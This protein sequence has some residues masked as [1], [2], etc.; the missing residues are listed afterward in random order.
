MLKNHCDHCNRIITRDDYITISKK[1][2]QDTTFC[3]FHCA[4]EW[5][6]QFGGDH[7]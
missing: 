4:H 1:G 6:G 5:T 7:E 3:C 2:T